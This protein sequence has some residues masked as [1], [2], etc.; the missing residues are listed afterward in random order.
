MQQR[1]WP[2]IIRTKTLLANILKEPDEIENNV[3]AGFT[4]FL[5][6]NIVIAKLR[7]SFGLN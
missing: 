2:Q 3:E 6:P 7:V 1:L 5:K 4:E